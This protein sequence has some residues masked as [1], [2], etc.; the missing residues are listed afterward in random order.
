MTGSLASGGA[1]GSMPEVGVARSFL[2]D[3]VTNTEVAAPL[4]NNFSRSP[5]DR[6][7][8][9]NNGVMPAQKNPPNDMTKAVIFSLG[10]NGDRQI[11]LVLKSIVEFNFGQIRLD[12]WKHLS[13][14]GS[15]SPE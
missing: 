5:V 6:I 1:P 9:P 2:T 3:T 7:Y 14:P 8:S 15:L 10:L 4:K 11:L 12:W 13:L